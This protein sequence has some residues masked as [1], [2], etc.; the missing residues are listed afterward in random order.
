MISTT[1]RFEKYKIQKVRTHVLLLVHCAL[2]SFMRRNIVYNVDIILKVRNW[3]LFVDFSILYILYKYGL[4]KYSL[5]NPNYFEKG[6]VP[7][8]YNIMPVYILYTYK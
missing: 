5:C 8:I 4:K 2:L 3:D 6:M 7:K 1:K